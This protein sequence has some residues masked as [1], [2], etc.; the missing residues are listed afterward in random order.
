MHRLHHLRNLVQQGNAEAF[1]KELN[2]DPGRTRIWFDRG[3]THQGYGTEVTKALGAYVLDEILTTSANRGGSKM[4]HKTA[5]APQTAGRVLHGA[6]WYDVFGRV[7]SFG[8]D[9]AIREKLIELAAPAPGE[10]VL[11]VGCGTGTLALALKSS[12]GTGEVHGIDASPEM[13]E[14]A[15]EKAAKAGSDID[16]QVALIEV[17]PFPDATFDLVTSS[18]MLHHLP[19]DLK[20]TGLDE[21]RRVLKPGG[22]FM[23]MD[24]AAHSHSPLGHLLS[25]FGHSRGE[26]MVDKLMPMLKDAGFSDVEGIP[27]RH[28]NF[29][30]IRAR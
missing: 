25:I 10:K 28:K 13:I 6:R 19:D 5:Y 30:F 15:K 7:I 22:R 16:F 18:L 4:H 8:R 23:A 29:A 26:S 14:V 27:T 12:V 1:A 9:K 20:R 17:I 3:F 11:D 24:F 21:V 2:L